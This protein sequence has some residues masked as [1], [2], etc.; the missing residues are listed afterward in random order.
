MTLVASPCFQ[1]NIPELGTWLL[2]C[3]FFWLWG[4]T[5]SWN[6]YRSFELHLQKNLLLTHFHSVSRTKHKDLSAFNTWVSGF[7]ASLH[8]LECKD[9]HQT[10]SWYTQCLALSCLAGAWFFKKRVSIVWI[11][12]RSYLRS[13]STFC[14][15]MRGPNAIFSPTVMCLKR[16]KLWNMKPTPLFCTGSVPTS[17][18]AKSRHSNW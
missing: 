6:A 14:F 1:A 18:S 13:R 3:S 5:W 17:S 15:W 10:A 7:S 11:N 4:L 2:S 8:G 12:L 16:A 9:S